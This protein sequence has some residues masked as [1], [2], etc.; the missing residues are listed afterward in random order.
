MII[1]G[2]ILKFSE[3]ICKNL[4]Q[5]RGPEPLLPFSSGHAT[6]HRMF[7]KVLIHPPTGAHNL[8]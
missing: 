4:L 7:G 3:D 8:R 6:A 1:H 2:N 5:V